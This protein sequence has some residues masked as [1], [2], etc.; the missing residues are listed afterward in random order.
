[1]NNRDG[2]TVDWEKFS[3]LPKPTTLESWCFES[4]IASFPADEGQLIY[5]DALQYVGWLNALPNV[6]GVT[7]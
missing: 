2:I 4:I 3:S 6:K 5:W 7:Q 1:M